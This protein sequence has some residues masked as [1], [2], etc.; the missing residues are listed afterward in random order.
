MAG[1]GAEQGQRRGQQPAQATPPSPSRP[2]ARSRQR[3]RENRIMRGRPEIDRASGR[4]AVLS[5]ARAPGARIRFAASGQS[6]SRRKGD[7]RRAGATRP[8]RAAFAGA[9]PPIS[10]VH[11]V[12][13]LSGIASRLRAVAAFNGGRAAGCWAPAHVL[14]VSCARRSRRDPRQ[15]ASGSKTNRPSR[16]TDDASE[17][18]AAHARP[19][20]SRRPA[21]PRRQPAP[22]QV[23]R[24]LARTCR[25]E[26]RQRLVE[27]YRRRRDRGAYKP[28]RWRSPPR[29]DRRDRTACRP[30][31]TRQRRGGGQGGRRGAAASAGSARAHRRQP[32]A[33]SAV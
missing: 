4:R 17:N 5:A 9:G 15:Y 12:H 26:R 8:D 25:I 16:I 13:R 27:Q 33:I 14:G 6:S 19:Q 24:R 3:P 31:R 10:V 29:A 1:R 23:S 28:T 21:M 7:E 18:A 20:C 32:P 22:A 2:C 11:G 30:G